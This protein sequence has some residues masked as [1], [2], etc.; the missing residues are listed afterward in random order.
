MKEIQEFDDDLLTKK[1]IDDI[2]MDEPFLKEVIEYEGDE[3]E[4]VKDVSNNEIK[5]KK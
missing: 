5:I 4:L 3:E 1:K 2:E